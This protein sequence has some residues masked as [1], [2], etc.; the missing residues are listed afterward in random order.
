MFIL[1]RKKFVTFTR[2]KSPCSPVDAKKSVLKKV[3]KTA[4]GTFLLII[5][6]TIV[7]FVLAGK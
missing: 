6:I 5:S 7:V 1:L 2:I 3:L 4:Y